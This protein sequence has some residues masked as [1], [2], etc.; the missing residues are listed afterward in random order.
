MKKAR[1]RKRRDDALR[2]TLPDLSTQYGRWA[3]STPYGIWQ[4][5]G[6]REVIFS[7]SYNPLWERRPGGLAR[8]VD[9]TEW[10]YDIETTTY[11]FDDGTPAAQVRAAIAELMRAWGVTPVTDHELDRLAREQE[12]ARQREAIACWRGVAKAEA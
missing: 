1:P 5:A 4:C 11:L 8:R 9:P 6:G 7:R 10:I 2:K 12:L 3:L